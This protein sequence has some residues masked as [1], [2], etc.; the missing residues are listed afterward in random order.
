MIRSRWLS[1]LAAVCA[2]P[3]AQGQ[4]PLPTDI[5]YFAEDLAKKLPDEG[6]GRFFTTSRDTK[7]AKPDGFQ[8]SLVFQ[9]G[10]QFRGELT[11]ITKDEIVW[12]RTDAKTLLRFPR[13]EIRRV[14]LVDE[15]TSGSP[16][17]QINPTRSQ[18]SDDKSSNAPATIKLPGGDWLFGNV[19]SADGQTFGLNLDA[20]STVAVGRELIEWLHFGQNPAPAFGFAGSALGM[21]GWLPTSAEM[22]T[23]AGALTVRGASWIGRAISP[24]ERFEVAFEIPADCEESLRL[25]LQPFGPQVNCYGTG[26]V[27]IRFGKKQISRL[28]YIEKFE[29]KSDPL[30]AEAQAEQGPVS[31]RVFYDGVGQQ[32]SV[33]RNGRQIGD[34]SFT[35]K[36]DAKAAGGNRVV[37]EFRING[38][39]FDREDRGS[40]TQPLKFN[41][42]RIQPWDGVAIKPGEAPPSGDQLSIKG[43]ATVA[44]RLE[45]VTEKELLFSAASKPR[46]EATMVRLN[47]PIAAMPDADALVMLGKQGEFCATEVELRDGK[48]SARSIFAPKLELPASALT[49]LN[50][51]K[52]DVPAGQQSDMLIFKNG[53]EFPGTLLDAEQGGALRWKMTSGQEV[54]FQ[55]GRIAGVRFASPEKAAKLA[56]GATI[57]LRSGDQLR[58]ELTGMDATQLHLRHAQLGPITIDRSKVARFFPNPRMEIYEGSRDPDAWLKSRNGDEKTDNA[59]SW[60][61]LDGVYILRTEGRGNAYGSNEMKGL[62]REISADLERFEVRGE[63]TFVNG[64]YGNATLQVAGKSGGSMQATIS[65]D[66]VQIIAY[67][68]RGQQPNWKTIPFRD[69]LP[70]ATTRLALRLFVDT[71]A[72]RTEMYINGVPIASTGR[73]PA[74]RM[75][76]P[77]GVVSFQSYANGGAPVVF[78][79]L[80]IGPWTGEL[81]RVGAEPGAITALANGDATPGAP[82]ELRDGQLSL[83]TELGPLD[84]ALEKVHSV[85]FGAA[86]QPE[87]AAARLRLVDGGAI[88]VSSFRWD[89]QEIT[90]HSAV[91]GDLRLPVKAVS[92]LIYDPAPIRAPV[93]AAAK[94]LAQKTAPDAAQ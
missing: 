47:Q 84:L 71:K 59:R 37:R 51:P 78:S 43:A 27:E 14:M 4:S 46:Q 73:T 83:E 36:E 52:R 70:E 64:G 8:H 26:T 9:N 61:Y 38:I 41:R 94:K 76:G 85:D 42:L 17:I 80:W 35:K 48:L 93:V 29:R 24:P 40:G 82:K 25:W 67:S 86:A 81:P 23:E 13:S 7:P 87:K 2:G 55:P 22:T 16:F 49:G 60:I 34:W 1:L 66:E 56:P 88:H 72:G 57:E 53:D 54:E 33:W 31:Y 3:L 44:G 11:E 39:C 6:R 90:A 19:L 30:P 68:P 92:E 10:R 62:S 5:N 75:S 21:E 15:A 12:R 20:N 79:N 89:G 65:L 58:G 91:L 69:K 32:V 74:D 77:C 45:S 28:L 63:V 50:F 18:K